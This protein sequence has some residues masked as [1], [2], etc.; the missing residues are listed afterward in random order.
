LGSLD[1]RLSKGESSSNCPTIAASACAIREEGMAVGSP[2]ACLLGL[3]AIAATG[4]VSSW[5][6]QDQ[7]SRVR[8]LLPHAV[9]D[10]VNIVWGREAGSA[11]KFDFAPQLAAKDRPR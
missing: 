9:L 6:N 3:E 10:P 1:G 2:G 8:S 4:A 5:H 11:R 7:C